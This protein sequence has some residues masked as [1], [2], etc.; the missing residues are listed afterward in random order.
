MPGAGLYTRLSA[1]YFLYFA[2]VGVVVPFFSYYLKH[3]GFDPVVGLTGCFANVMGLPLCHLAR[4]LRRA[5]AAIPQS[6]PRDCQAA[7][8]Y[9]CPVYDQILSGTAD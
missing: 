7:L 1:F 6:L 8:D 9:S 4:N 3:R 2:A 5:G